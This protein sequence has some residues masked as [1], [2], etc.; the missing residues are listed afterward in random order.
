M[1]VASSSDSLSS[2]FKLCLLGP[3]YPHRGYHMIDLLVEVLHLV[4]FFQHNPCLNE[5]DD[6]SKFIAGL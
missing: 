4:N 6:L 3:K 2:F 5:T 1:Y